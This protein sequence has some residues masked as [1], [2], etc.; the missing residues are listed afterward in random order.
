MSK[1][2][3]GWMA[4][5]IAGIVGISSAIYIFMSDYTLEDGHLITKESVCDIQIKEHFDGK[6]IKVK[7]YVYNKYKNKHFFELVIASDNTK[8]ALKY[9]LL[10]LHRYSE[11]KDS[12]G[13]KI[14][15][16]S[17]KDYFIVTYQDGKTKRFSVPHCNDDM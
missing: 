1:H 16:E 11:L 5:L 10:P 9:Y 14:I 8:D 13:V 15:K 4:L 7:R 6:V 17:G 2:K 3:F 12:Q